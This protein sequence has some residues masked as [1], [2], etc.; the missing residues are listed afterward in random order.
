MSDTASENDYVIRKL[1]VP[2]K[3]ENEFLYLRAADKG[4][5]AYG[6]LFINAL[7]KNIEALLSITEIED[8]LSKEDTEK[9]IKDMNFHIMEFK[10][11]YYESISSLGK[12]LKENSSTSKTV[13]KRYEIYKKYKPSLVIGKGYENYFG[14]KLKK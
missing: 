6:D 2:S 12:K 1:K 9:K 13:A 11:D 8:N 4:Q 10:K 7:N 3:Y 14:K 5:I